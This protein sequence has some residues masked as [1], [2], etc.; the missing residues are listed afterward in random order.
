MSRSM[1][2]A[3]PMRRSRLAAT[4]VLLATTTCNA[5]KVTVVGG[6]GFLGSRVCKALVA[7]GADVTSVSKS[8]R[9]PS[10]IAEEPFAKKVSW[11]AADLL[12][13]DEAALDAAMASADSVVSCVGVVDPNPAVLRRGNGDANVKAFAAAQR[14][15]VGRA[16]YVSVASEVMACEENWL[17][18]AKDEFGAYFAGK[19]AAEQAAA[20]AVG[21]DA[22]KLCV[23]RPTFIYG[24]ESFEV[25]LPGKFV[26]P[27]VSA[28]YGRAVEEVLTLPPIQALADALPGLAK[29]ALR[30]PVSVEA[31]A[32][33]C[34]K[35]ALGA[36][37]TGDATRRAVGTL[38]GTEPIRAAAGQPPP[39]DLSEGLDRALDELGD[40][41]EK[42]LN[43]VQQKIDGK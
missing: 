26:A 27:R 4:V 31:V 1:Q 7:E 41:T 6:S 10:W 13:A 8:G 19:R 32:T 22:T 43:W 40:Q 12:S 3:A 39:K 38:D 11:I 5:L 42:L 9:A 17:P 23:L 28:A 14:A 21:G 20:D 24:G 2:S 33:A 34:A 18:F 35:A 25:P 29:V 16:V 37:T 36:L 30:P 15:G